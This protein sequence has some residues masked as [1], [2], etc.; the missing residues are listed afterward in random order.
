MQ[1]SHAKMA[2]PETTLTRHN[3]EAKIVKRCWEDEEF[4]REFTS[5]PA[6]AFVKY[7]DVPAEGLPKIVVH[8]ESAGTWD[9][10]LPQRPANAD[11]LSDRDLE[12]VA[13]GT[14]PQISVS[15]GQ[16]I[17][18]SAGQASAVISGLLSLVT[19][20][21]AAGLSATLQKGW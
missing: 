18:A 12:R 13:G 10:V 20:G 4:R 19:M 17:S 14:T 7:L 8:E 21:G 2:E 5:D 15:V 11:E 3:L 16:A 6:G 1:T 9:I